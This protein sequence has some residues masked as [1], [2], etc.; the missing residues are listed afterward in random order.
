VSS[1][2]IRRERKSIVFMPRQSV[3]LP[4]HLG[5]QTSDLA[6]RAA[7]I[8]VDGSLCRALAIVGVRVAICELVY[9]K[10]ILFA[11]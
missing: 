4:S 10:I 7:S 5:K 6:V 11:K 2:Y 8:W 1:S 3:T 9:R